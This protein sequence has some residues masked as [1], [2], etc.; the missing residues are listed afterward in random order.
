MSRLNDKDEAQML[1]V[2]RDFY[3]I[4]LVGIEG[5]CFDLLGSTLTEKVREAVPKAAAEV[6]SLLAL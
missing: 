1:L 4:S 2:F 5:L 6:I 3:E